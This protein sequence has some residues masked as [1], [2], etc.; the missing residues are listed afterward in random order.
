MKE[1]Y[2]LIIVGGGPCGLSASLYAGRS[3][4]KTLLLEEF[5]CGGQ[6]LNTYEIKNYPGFEN[7][8]GPELAEKIQKQAQNFDVVVK[9]ERVVDLL[10][11]GDIKVIKT[12]KNE[13]FAKTVILSVGAKPR[14]L[15]L[16]REEQFVGRG[17]SYCAICDGGFFKGKRVA[18]VGGGDSAIED[19]PYLTNLASKTYLVNRS[20]KFRAQKILLDRVKQLEQDQKV[21]IFEDCVVDQLLGENKLEGVMIKNTQT[22]EQT[23]LDID[24]L[25]I[26]IGRVPNTD[27]LVGKI[28]LDENGYI[29]TDNNLMTNIKGVFAGGDAIKKSLRQIIT[30]SSDGAI[31]ATNAQIFLQNAKNEK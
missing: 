22:G 12:A 11:D 25:F 30:A 10:L 18:V 31:C 4:I 13:Y 28:D 27:F 9:Y 15:N 3:G 19:V 23:K 20:K 1:I 21:E 24:G 5:A 6:I 14:K 26:E 16:E 17:V 7:I 8:S 2:D 29:I